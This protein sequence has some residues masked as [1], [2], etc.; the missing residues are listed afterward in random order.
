MVKTLPYVGFTYP[1]VTGETKLEAL[2]RIAVEFPKMQVWSHYWE[3]GKGYPTFTEDFWDELPDSV[4]LVLLSVKDSNI[5]ALVANFP[6]IPVQWRGRVAITINHEP[7]QWRSEAD[8]RGDLSPTV[9]W[10]KIQELLNRRETAMWSTWVL[11][12]VCMTEDR[13]RTE[14]TFWE[15]H[16]GS[17]IRGEPRLDFIACDV[18]NIGR[19]VVRTG[20]DMFAEF[21]KFV[22]DCKNMVVFREYGQVTPKDQPTDSAVVVN[23]VEE[24]WEYLK[25]NADLVL[26]VVWYNNHNNTLSDPAKIRRP[27]TFALLQRMVEEAYM[28]NTTPVTD[29]PNPDHPQ[30]QHGYRQ[31]TEDLEALVRDAYDQGVRD[32][33]DRVRRA[34]D[35]PV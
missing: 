25:A 26:A 34:L 14:R 6:N 4:V 35:G 28:A 13:F 17:K 9:W 27:Q 16:W 31:A 7:D 29:E 3:P 12:Y 33:T 5:E 22:R 15:Q 18:F 24:H 2:K 32:V 23:G 11:V 8:P 21:L 1:T 10:S 20:A 19:T 30:Y